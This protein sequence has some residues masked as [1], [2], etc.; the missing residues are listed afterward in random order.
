MLA[1]GLVEWQSLMRRG[2]DAARCGNTALA[3]HLY[4]QS[5][6][7]AQSLMAHGRGFSADDR[8]AAFVVTHLNLADLHN[9]LEEPHAA[10][11]HL[12]GAHE[13][14]MALVRDPHGDHDMQQAAFRH[15]RE[16]HAAL[17]SHLSE[18]GSHP[19]VL[20]ALRAGCMPFPIARSHTLH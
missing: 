20:D 1:P 13:T 10:V 18:H 9:D 17:L 11:A 14:L 6:V 12:C 5:L 8:L 19:A 4:Q 3:G 15:S 7:I 16:T 2:C